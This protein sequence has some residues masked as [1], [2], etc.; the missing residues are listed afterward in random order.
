MI[1][2]RAYKEDDIFR[3]ILYYDDK[4]PLFKSYIVSIYKQPR[5][6]FSRYISCF[7]L[8]IDCIHKPIIYLS[9]RLRYIDS[10]RFHDWLF[11]KALD[12]NIPYPRYKYY[13]YTSIV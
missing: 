7:P 13:P 8:W 5:P 11:T 12:N 6:R 9:Y 2:Y 1:T 4:E 3:K 10:V